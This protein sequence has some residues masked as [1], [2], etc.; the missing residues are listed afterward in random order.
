MGTDTLQEN[1]KPAAVQGHETFSHT[2]P[3]KARYSTAPG[4]AMHYVDEGKGKILLFLHGEPTWGYLFRQT[5]PFRQTGSGHLGRTG[6]HISGKVFS[7][8]IPLGFP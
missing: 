7:S 3:Y 1:T 4:F 5:R 8:R 6:P 2:W